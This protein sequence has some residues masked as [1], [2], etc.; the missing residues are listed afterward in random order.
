M[1]M[2]GRPIWLDPRAA[3]GS[4]RQPR[5][6]RLRDRR[7]AGVDPWPRRNSMCGFATIRSGWRSRL[8]GLALVLALPV[9]DFGAISSRSQLARLERGKVAP[10]E[11]DWAAMA[12][13]FGPSGRRALQRIAAA[14]APDQ[15]VLASRA[16]R[17]GTRYEVQSDLRTAQAEATARR[18][19]QDRDSGSRARRS[20]A[21]LPG[22]TRDVRRALSLRAG[23]D[24]RPASRG[25]RCARAGPDDGRR[26]RPPGLPDGTRKPPVGPT[27]D[28]GA[29]AQVGNLA[30]APVEVREVTRKQLFVDG[31]PVGQP[32]E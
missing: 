12:F 14:G 4:D 16:L 19:G 22:G 13:E 28:D 31:Q 11:F 15:R 3:V 17:S 7:L 30:N 23:S 18:A 25:D 6:N 29:V 32:F 2:Q 1:G 20:P 21:R 10:A 27:T 26:R 9:F 8:C 24:R 5:R